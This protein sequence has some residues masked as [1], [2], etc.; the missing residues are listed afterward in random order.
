MVDVI[1]DS[2]ADGDTEVPHARNQPMSRFL[3]E[4]ERDIRD[5]WPSLSKNLEQSV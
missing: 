5:I 3:D 4:V 2:G 1:D